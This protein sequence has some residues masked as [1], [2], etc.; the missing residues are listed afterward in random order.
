MVVSAD[1][2]TAEAFEDADLDFV[3]L[4]GEEVVE[5]LGEALEGFSGQAED[6][7]GVEVGAGFLSQEAEVFFRALVVL[8]SSDSFCDLWIESL[9]PDFELEGSRGE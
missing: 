5:A 8:S 6:E 2:G 9:D 3:G 1:G 4:K 7:V